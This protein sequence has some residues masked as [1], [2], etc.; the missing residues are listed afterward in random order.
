MGSSQSPASKSK[1][2]HQRQQKLKLSHTEEQAALQKQKDAGKSAA[3]RLRRM[4]R[5]SAEV[6]RRSTY[7]HSLAPECESQVG[8]VV[9]RLESLL[10]KT[11]HAQVKGSDLTGLLPTQCLNDE[12]MDFFGSLILARSSSRPGSGILNVLVLSVFFWKALIDGS[13][14]VNQWTDRESVDIFSKDAILLPVHHVSPPHWTA[15]SINFRKKR[16]ESYDSLGNDH[17]QV[18]ELLRGYM[19]KEHLRKKGAPFNFTGWVNHTPG[20][21]P[22]AVVIEEK[23]Y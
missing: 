21:E 5:N 4:A 13:S 12:V 7:S 8:R 17:P 6:A 18:Y 14:K 20:C 16:V 11:A 3:R 23:E 1:N 22:F 19:D 9:R 15:A 2:R 10:I